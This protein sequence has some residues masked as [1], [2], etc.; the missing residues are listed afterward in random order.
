M[1]EYCHIRR[2]DVLALTTIPWE[3]LKDAQA[4][5]DWAELTDVA[6]ALRQALG[7]EQRLR[8]FAALT[9]FLDTPLYNRLAGF[10]VTP[11]TFYT[12][13]A[14]LMLRS[15]YTIPRYTVV[16]D[17]DRVFTVVLDIPPAY[18]PSREFMVA[19]AGTFQKSPILLGLPQAQVDAEITDRRGVFRIRLPQNPPFT[20]RLR[21]LF[22][23]IAA[24]LSFFRIIRQQLDELAASYAQLEQQTTNFRNVL[25]GSSDGILVVRDGRILHANPAFARLLRASSTEE[26]IGQTTDEFVAKEDL[27]SLR[28]WAS[29][30]PQPT[31]S[32]QLRIRLP[33]LDAFAHVEFSAP[34]I[35]T[36]ENQPATLWLLRDISE[37]HALETALASARQREQA[38][39]ARDLHDGLGQHLTGLAFKLKALET[40][41]H[42]QQSPESSATA[43]IVALA[44]RAATHARDLAHGLAPVDIDPQ[45]LVP[46]LRLLCSNVSQL[47]QIEC[48]LRAPEQPLAFGRDTANQIYRATQEAI[49][50]AHRHGHARKID[51]QLTIDPSHALTL[52]I[53][54]DGC[55]LPRAFNPD[56]VVSGF[57]LKIMRHRL[58]SLGGRVHIAK[59]PVAHGAR[60]TLIAPI[61][62]AEDEP[63]T[64][65]AP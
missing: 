33:A 38:S 16:R 31:E 14:P 44:N 21:S 37:R 42:Q 7:G 50:N 36:W 20:Q 32:R 62:R 39:L 18:A 61:T 3:K 29:A 46:A 11:N 23:G 17:S 64:C 10:F 4:R 43:E 54:D 45:G 12:K 9:A 63:F 15:C 26:L 51:I 57:G 53:D 59:S 34:R 28:Q 24:G 41:L 56:Q 6:R 40:R 47:F 35:I 60:I 19:A 27:V 58:G 30:K 25:A 8:E 5:V 22:A 55:G 49:T 65:S 1:H 52:T 13:L 2:D 48:T